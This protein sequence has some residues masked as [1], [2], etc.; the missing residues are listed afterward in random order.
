MNEIKDKLLTTLE[1]EENLT[2]AIST[3]VEPITVRKEHSQS[4]KESMNNMLDSDDEDEQSGNQI[5]DTKA[6]L[7]IQ[8]MAEKR[9]P[10]DQDQSKY[11]QINS[12]KFGGLSHIA[13]TYLSSP[14][15]SVPSEQLFSAAGI[16]YDPHRNRLLGDKAANAIRRTNSVNAMNLRR[17][18]QDETLDVDHQMMEVE[19]KPALWDTY[20]KSYSDRILKTRFRQEVK[21][22][23]TSKKYKAKT[24]IGKPS[25]LLQK[26]FPKTTASTSGLLSC[27]NEKTKFIAAELAM[28]YHTVKHNLLYNSQDYSIKLNKIIYVESKTATNI[29]LARTK[30]EALVTKVLGPHSLQSV[31]D[32]LNKDNVFYCL[33]TDASNRIKK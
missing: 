12:K 14:A 19:T 30:M 6:N 23:L 25:V 4:L 2:T 22:H 27:F 3:G 10:R 17:R 7:L 13:R 5:S 26:F 31:I 28:T 16:L 11:W 29:R 20:A 21:Q 9:L 8:Y 1:T 24:E 18:S 32:Q 15:T 33:Q